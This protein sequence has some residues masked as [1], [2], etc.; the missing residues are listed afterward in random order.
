[1]LW[2]EGTHEYSSNLAGITTLLSTTL[3][4]GWIIDTCATHHFNPLK[5][6]L[7]SLKGLQGDCKI[8]VPTGGKS[9]ISNEGDTLVMGD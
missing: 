1:M 5:E 8:Q 6:I 3:D 7:S 9:K 4:H 2:K